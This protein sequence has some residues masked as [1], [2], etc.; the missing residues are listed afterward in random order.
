VGRGD[1]AGAAE[2]DGEGAVAGGAAGAEK[3]HSRSLRKPSRSRS[4]ARQ[5]A[6]RSQGAGVRAGRVCRLDWRRRR[7]R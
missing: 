4:M 2:A 1:V 3:V 6:S 7:R 5:E